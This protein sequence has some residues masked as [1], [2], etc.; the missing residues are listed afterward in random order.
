MWWMLT[1]WRSK[2]NGNK[3]D[4]THFSG[5]VDRAVAHG[6]RRVRR[7]SYCDL[8]ADA[9]DR[10]RRAFFNG[11]P[12]SSARDDPSRAYAYIHASAHQ[13]WHF[14][15]FNFVSLDPGRLGAGLTR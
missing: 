5:F 2:K 4:E 9:V 14:P 6:L 1:R 13:R 8:P 12:Q 15:R 10:D 11:H 3:S 7:V